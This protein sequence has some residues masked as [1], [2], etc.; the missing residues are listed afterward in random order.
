MNYSV[1]GTATAGLDH[2]LEAGTVTFA[3]GQTKQAIVLPVT[4]D[5]LL[6]GNETVVLTL[7]GAQN[8]SLGTA[9]HTFTLR[10]TPLSVGL[11]SAASAVAAP[12][13][14]NRP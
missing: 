3:P 8:A 10:D 14:A 9:V 1:G 6:E 12:T 7:S 11:L 2:T 13:T 4:I 5:D